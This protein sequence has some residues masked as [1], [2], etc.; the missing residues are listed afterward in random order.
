MVSLVSIFMTNILPYIFENTILIINTLEQDS[1]CCQCQWSLTPAPCN[2]LEKEVNFEQKSFLILSVKMFIISRYVRSRCF[3]SKLENRQII[4]DTA[5]LGQPGDN[6][7][8]SLQSKLPLTKRYTNH[9]TY[10]WH[11]YS[12]RV[13]QR[14]NL[15]F[16]KRYHR[17]NGAHPM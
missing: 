17:E 3:L 1:G 7:K 13:A 12:L 5:Y 9:H 2:G 10:L 15:I 16:I 6:L 8:H 11:G 14:Y 4:M